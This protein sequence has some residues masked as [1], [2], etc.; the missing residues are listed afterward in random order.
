M[1]RPTLTDVARVAGVHHSTVSRA[2]RNHPG[3]PE[4]TRTRIQTI[5]KNIG[6]IPDPNLSALASYKN[7][8]R[9]PGFLSN[10]AWITN[11]PKE[12]GWTEN[13]HFLA[14]FHGAKKRA[15]ELG[16][17]LEI[18]WL[19][20]SVQSGKSPMT[21]L[22]ARGIRGLLFCPQPSP[23]LNIEMDLQDFSAISFGYTL[24]NPRLHNVAL[25]HFRSIQMLTRKLVQL[26]YRRPKLLLSKVSDARVNFSWSAGYQTAA[27]ELPLPFHEATYLD[28]N[29][30]KEFIKSI[31]KDE[32]DVVLATRGWAIQAMRILTEAGYKVPDDIGIAAVNANAI[33]AGL[34][35][36]I[37]LGELV[38]SHGID[39]ISAMIQ[40]GERGVPS[41]VKHM[42]T[43]GEFYLGK[44]LKNK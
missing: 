18:F 21:I 37:E 24:A 15:A 44:T 33:D 26:G 40:R 27:R 13:P 32:P 17:A 16:F 9:K 22:R 7:Q 11:F 1:N 4:S 28:T 43:D 2:L 38:G 6:Y 10:L 12:D 30:P 5:A 25:D 23:D 42:S 39:M 3:I 19:A 14:Y 41:H 20:G 31:L 29:E 34:G 35:G 36:V 8:R